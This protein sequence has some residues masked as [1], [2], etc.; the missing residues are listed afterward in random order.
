M[1]IFSQAVAGAVFLGN[2]RETLPASVDPSN[3]LEDVDNLRPTPLW[4]AVV[5]ALALAI[6]VRSRASVSRL[7]WDRAR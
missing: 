4:P 5:S 6:K 7:P 1:S 2:L 3:I